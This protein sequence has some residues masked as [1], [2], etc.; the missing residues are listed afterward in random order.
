MAYD[1]DDTLREWDVPVL[2]MFSDKDLAFKP[3]EGRRIA[4]LAPNGRF[5]LVENAGHYLQEDAG[6]EIAERIVTFL[7]DEANIS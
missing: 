6:V 1:W 4:D 2:V 3:A 7:R 5:Q